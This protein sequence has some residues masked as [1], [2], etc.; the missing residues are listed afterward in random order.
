MRDERDSE[1][2]IS[3][4]EKQGS[5]VH[6]KS[7]TFAMLFVVSHTHIYTQTHM[8]I[9]SPPPPHTHIHAHTHACKYASKHKNYF[10]DHDDVQTMHNIYIH[11]RKHTNTYM[12][13]NTSATFAVL[14]YVVW[15]V[16]VNGG[17]FAVPCEPV[18][19]CMH[20]MKSAFVSTCCAL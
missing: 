18:V 14:C 11:K 9:R 20:G 17:C 1:R 19:V 10:R 6:T 16:W 12:N 3:G 8:H 4:H 15:M 7:I 13:T 5:V 2:W